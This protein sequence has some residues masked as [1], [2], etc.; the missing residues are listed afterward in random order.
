MHPSQ[1]CRDDHTGV[2]L[3]D[4]LV[5]VLGF[6]S[7]IARET[8]LVKDI[9]PNPKTHRNCMTSHTVSTS[10]QISVSHGHRQK[11]MIFTSNFTINS[12]R[13]VYP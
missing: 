12:S 13:H 2:F 5:W 3:G 1:I 4:G 8:P 9:N 10:K 7:A 6:S 11:A